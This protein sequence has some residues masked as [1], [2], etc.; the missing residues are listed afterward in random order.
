MNKQVLKL[1]LISITLAGADPMHASA[2]DSDDEQ[3]GFWS[4]ITRSYEPAALPS[5]SFDS[6]LSRF[7]RIA[8]CASLASGMKIS[9]GGRRS[10]EC[11][12]LIKAIREHEIHVANKNKAESTASTPLPAPAPAAPPTAASTP[13]A[14]ISEG[15]LLLPPG[16]P[17]LNQ[18]YFEAG[19][20]LSDLACDQWF[21]TLGRGDQKVGWFKDLFQIVGNTLIGFAGF[22]GASASALG[23]GALGLASGGA[24]ADAFRSNFLYG[25]VGLV[26]QAVSKKRETT[27]EAVFSDIEQSSENG[28][29]LSYDAATRLLLSYHNIC[30]PEG[31][32]IVT[33]ELSTGVRY[34]TDNAD[35][36]S[37]VKAAVANATPTPAPTS[38]PTAS[39]SPSAS[40]TPT[41]A[42]S[43]E[44]NVGELLKDT[45]KRGAIAR[46]RS[47][48]LPRVVLE[49]R[50]K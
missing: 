9:A 8:H 24:V 3:S 20:T 7:Q 15:K 10:A 42:P 14:T 39:P 43:P 11:D 31:I 35:L 2:N 21:G 22:N 13:G 28:T 16:N 19:I 45:Q 36:I 12:N 32:A 50:S 30:S 48:V 37:K 18:Y 46:I 25:T 38:T 47:G 33:K 44:K 17:S 4:S 5:V 34:V 29:N 49:E 27:L 1:S 23:K 40:P 26:H 41:A 6:Q